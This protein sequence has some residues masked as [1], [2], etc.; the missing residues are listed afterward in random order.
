M[1]DGVT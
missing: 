1:L